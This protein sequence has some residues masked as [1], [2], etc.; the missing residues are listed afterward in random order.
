[1]M[2]GQ[3]WCAIL[4]RILI[5]EP[6]IREQIESV[7]DSSALKYLSSLALTVAKHKVRQDKSISRVENIDIDFED[8]HGKSSKKPD[9]EELEEFAIDNSM[10]QAIDLD[11][12]VKRVYEQLSDREQ[13]VF[14]AYFVNNVSAKEIALRLK[15]SA[16]TIFMTI[17]RISKKFSEIRDS[18]MGGDSGI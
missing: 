8:F 17:S 1:M 13:K 18:E 3:A 14:D 2:T 7:D 4:L 9:E 10:D 15:V 11:H 16:P 6:E 12:L 5:V